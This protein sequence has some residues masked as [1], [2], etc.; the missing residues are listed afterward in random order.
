[1]SAGAC[2]GL[3]WRD[4]IRIILLGVV[5]VVIVV[6]IL[7]VLFI[8]LVLLVLFII[9]LV[10][11]EFALLWRVFARFSAVD[12]RWMGL[13]LLCGRSRAAR[14]TNER[15]VL[16]NLDRARERTGTGWWGMCATRGNVALL[17]VRVLL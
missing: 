15:S 3:G 5:I 1:V 4:L 8:F 6:V 14:C 7:L 9:L 16:V 11:I 17:D 12:L 13:R 10:V 2:T